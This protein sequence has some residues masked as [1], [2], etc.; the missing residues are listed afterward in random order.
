MAA[1]PVAGLD[2]IYW[3]TQKD[4]RKLTVGWDIRS[5]LFLMSQCL[6]GD[7]TV[8][9]IGRFIDNMEGSAQEQSDEYGKGKKKWTCLNI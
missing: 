9:Q 7:E 3:E 2:G 6:E 8:A 1:A 4:K 5:G